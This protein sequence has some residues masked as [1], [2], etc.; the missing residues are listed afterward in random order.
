MGDTHVQVHGGR[1][2]CFELNTEDFGL[3]TGEKYSVPVA[4]QLVNLHASL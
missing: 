4:F 2:L 1:K 3:Q